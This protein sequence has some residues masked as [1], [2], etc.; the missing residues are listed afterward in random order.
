[1]V[2]H[3]KVPLP[4]VRGFCVGEVRCARNKFFTNLILSVSVGRELSVEL[5]HQ[6]PI[7]AFVSAE[8]RHDIVF[9]PFLSEC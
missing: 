5:R 1:M 7:G 6:R 3:E 9:K 8:P 4:F 2:L